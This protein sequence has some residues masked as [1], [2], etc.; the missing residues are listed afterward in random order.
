M[1]KHLSV[2]K[3]RSAELNHK[4]A[5]VFTPALQKIE[6]SREEAL[7]SFSSIY[8]GTKKALEGLTTE[9]KNSDTYG[10]K[11]TESEKDND[12]LRY[13]NKQLKNKVKIQEETLE[14][15]KK[16]IADLEGEVFRLKTSLKNTQETLSK[17]PLDYTPRTEA[18]DLESKKLAE[19]K[20]ASVELAGSAEEK[21]SEKTPGMAPQNG[22]NMPKP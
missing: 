12:L 4:V 7:E 3:R 17:T 1:A 22:K 20:D 6:K 13:E 14:K 19:T 9:F 8:E 18:K 2:S 11:L 21:I 10:Q 15:N 5:N 16:R